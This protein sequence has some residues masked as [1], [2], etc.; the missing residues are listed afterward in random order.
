M[1]KWLVAV[2]P[3]VV[4]LVAL[5]LV[6]CMQ[7]EAADAQ[8]QKEEP[9]AQ[10]P[11]EKPAGEQPGEKEPVVAQGEG[12]KPAE[13]R[14]GEDKPAK[15]KPEEKKAP[16]CKSF[17]EKSLHYTGEGMRYWYEEQGGFMQLT[18][19]PYKD[20]GC[21]SCHADSCDKCHAEK[22]DDKMVFTVAKAQK[23]ETCLACHKRAG[24]A[25]K[26]DKKA[27]IEDVHF[28]AGLVCADCH[29]GMDVHG[30]GKSYKSMRDPNA[31][32]VSCTTKECHDDVDMTIRPHSKHKKKNIACTA[33]HVS[34]T[35]TCLNC[36]FDD[37]LKRKKRVSGVNFFPNKS[38]TLLV[39]HEGKVTTG[40]A[41][42]LVSKG[43]KFVTY[44]PYFTHSI[45]KEG[46]KCNDCHS[47]EAAKKMLKGK[48]VEMAKF[49]DGK[50]TH[51]GGVIPFVPE[52]LKWPWLDKDKD[53]K[54]VEI[55]N[56]EKPVVQKACYA[57][58]LTESQLKKL[59]MKVK[60]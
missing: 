24:A 56:D 42:T 32:K 46:K 47:N 10:Q 14:A 51:A 11:Q 4:A 8:A 19:I 15:E 22:K 25:M 17:F 3:V 35:I 16:P 33:C 30:D 57:E 48:Q 55:K 20:L 49:E 9:V 12:E 23:K 27:G 26:F 2:V 34:S 43:K 44:V 31:V 52:F 40:N 60:E 38:W 37:F 50:L 18:G 36:H 58:P 53:G 21:K 6:S 29:K 13:K 59:K 45:V 39:N 7:P 54:W 28:A 5:V 41:Q 1:E